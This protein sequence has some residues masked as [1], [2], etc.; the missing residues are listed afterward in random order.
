MNLKDTIVRIARG[1][2]TPCTLADGGGP[3]ILV[4]ANGSKWWRL[5]YR[6]DGRE[7]RLS[8]GVYPVVSL[9]EAYRLV[10]TG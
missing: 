6:V 1:K 5:K 7:K 3:F 4:N 9:L 10:T 8:F 2:A